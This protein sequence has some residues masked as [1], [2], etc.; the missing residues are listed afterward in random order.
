MTELE[1]QMYWS[2]IPE[3]LQNNK[4][5]HV[6]MELAVEEFRI[7]LAN[8][9]SFTDLIDPDKVPAQFIEALGGIVGFEGNVNADE[10]SREALQRIQSVY[11]QRG[12]DKSI[13]MSAN[14]GSN[15][16][17]L[18]GQLFVPGYSIA[19]EDATII[20]TAEKI[21]THS[22]SKFSGGD[23]YSD[24]SVYRSGVIMITVPYID[25][26]VRK[27]VLGNVP[28]GVKYYFKIENFMN[29]TNPEEA[30]EFGEMSLMRTTGVLAI[31]DEEILG[32][33]QSPGAMDAEISITYTA[34]ATTNALV[35]SGS[36]GNRLRSGSQIIRSEYG[37]EVHLGASGLSIS[38]LGLGL[39]TEGAV[40]VSES[41]EVLDT[42]TMGGSISVIHD[43]SREV[44]DLSVI[45]QC[46][47]LP[48]RS[49]LS[50]LRSSKYVPSGLFSNWVDGYVLPTT[51]T[52]SNFMGN[53]SDLLDFTPFE[54]EGKYTLGE[55]EVQQVV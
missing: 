46:H 50:A 7:D 48:S 16:G 43:L 8:I 51:N 40:I 30:G 35:R 55:I 47:T 45:S 15:E 33:V 28:A 44:L 27:A 36:L 42:V 32:N 1:K 14:H 54:L 12:T 20:F 49:T 25:D 53:V 13:L 11:S 29:P 9:E 22:R 39:D 52:V 2:K 24:G 3:V 41:G 21:F 31:T 4:N 38:M 5:F 23:V 18:G 10:F 34:E 37:I 6:F 19:S 17:W 26:K